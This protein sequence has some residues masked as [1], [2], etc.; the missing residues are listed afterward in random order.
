[1][2][3][4]TVQLGHM[5]ERKLTDSIGDAAYRSDAAR[6]VAQ[7]ALRCGCEVV[8]VAG[9]PAGRPAAAAVPWRAVFQG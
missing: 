4:L 5:V 3:V 7:E 2:A 1:M 9:L 8:L 6:P